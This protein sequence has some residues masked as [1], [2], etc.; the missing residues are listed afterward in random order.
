M[1]M[2][3][4]KTSGWTIRAAALFLLS[5]AALGGGHGVAY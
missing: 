4:L 3:F 5:V 2:Q 1:T